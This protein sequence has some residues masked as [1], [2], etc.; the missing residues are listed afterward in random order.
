MRDSLTRASTAVAV[1]AAFMLAAPA[2]AQQQQ[3]QQAPE[4]QG[5][6]TPQGTPSSADFSEAQLDA[7]AAAAEDISRLQQEYDV[8]LQAA[9]SS[10]EAEDLRTEAT[11]AIMDALEEQGITPDEY[12]SIVAAAQ[13]DPTLYAAI[14]ERMETAD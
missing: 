1:L 13:A 12:N 4:Q 8:K 7:F 11:D 10:E 2:G 14:I 9:A 5:M 3:P 6:Q